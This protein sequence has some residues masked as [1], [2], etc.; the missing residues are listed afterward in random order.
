M[1]SH[2][3]GVLHAEGYGGPPLY[4]PYPTDVMELLPQLWPRTVGRDETG[5]PDRRRG[6]RRQPGRGARHGC[7]RARR[8]RLP[9]SRSRV[10]SRL[11][12]RVRGT[13]RRRRVLRRQG[14]PLHRRRAVG[15]RRGPVPRRVHRRRARGSATRGVPGGTDRVPRQQQ[16][17]GRAPRRA[18]LRRGTH[19]RRLLPGDRPPRGRRGRARG[20][21]AGHG[22]GHRGRRGAHP[23]VHR[24]RA[25]GPEVRLQPHRRP[26]ARG[27]PPPPRQTGRVRPAGTAQPHRQ[28]DLRHRRLRGRGPPAR[29][30]PRAGRRR[31]R[32]PLPGARPRWRLRHRLHLAAHPARRGDA[33][34][35]DGGHRRAR[36]QGGR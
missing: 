20:R 17:H 23:R 16:E 31:A 3:A 21:R 8:G 35:G 33:R 4:L 5:S 6:R 25:R 26:G 29:G 28:P 2:E 27:R 36:A 12:D 1:R 18:G 22:A 10:P 14:L 7:L 9:L 34:A 32:S 24:H 15:R 19:R 11:R 30:A 13:G